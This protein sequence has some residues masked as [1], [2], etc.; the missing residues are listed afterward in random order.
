MYIEQPS[1]GQA[2]LMFIDNALMCVYVLFQIHRQKCDKK[3]KLIGGEAKVV[4]ELNAR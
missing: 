4:F 3:I 1:H 2:T